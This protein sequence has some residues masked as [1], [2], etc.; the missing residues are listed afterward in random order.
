[1]IRLFIYII[2]F[3]FLLI[4]SY[5]ILLRNSIVNR[6]CFSYYHPRLKKLPKEVE[7]LNSELVLHYSFECLINYVE[8]SLPN[9]FFHFGL[10]KQQKFIE[11]YGHC[12]NMDLLKFVL[13]GKVRSKEIGLKVLDY[14]IEYV[15][16]EPKTEKQDE[17]VS[18]YLQRIKDLYIWWS[19]QRTFVDYA[20]LENLSLEKQIEIMTKELQKDHEMLA[21]L[22]EIRPYLYP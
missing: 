2:L 1:M 18:S 19:E 7:A 4:L 17:N 3:P 20:T 8:V 10:Y 21:K 9:I 11:K 16:E 12:S 22:Y 6:C 13:L 5:I 15:K 14:Y